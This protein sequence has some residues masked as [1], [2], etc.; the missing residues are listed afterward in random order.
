VEGGTTQARLKTAQ[1]SHARPS[2]CASIDESSPSSSPHQ[3]FSPYPLPRGRFGKTSPASRHKL[4]E[5]PAPPP[6][7]QDF[8]AFPFSPY[9]IQ[10][11]FMSFLY[12]ALSSGPGALA[13]LESPTGELAATVTSPSLLS[14]PA[15]SK[16]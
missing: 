3:Q 14:S 13:F 8:P 1:R 10:K 7:R 9:P 4:D 16:P 12:G 2:I 11:D 6:P 5:M 15:P